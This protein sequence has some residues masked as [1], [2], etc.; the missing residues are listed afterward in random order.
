[1]FE[2]IEIVEG[3]WDAV[4]AEVTDDDEH[5]EEDV[6]DLGDADDARKKGKPARSHPLPWLCLKL[7]RIL[8]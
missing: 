2:T 4:A 7:S 6:E 5:V 3:Y 8:L 1:V